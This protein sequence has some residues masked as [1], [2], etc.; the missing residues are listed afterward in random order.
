[1]MT[2][3]T[4]QRAPSFYIGDVEIKG[5]VILAP[6]AGIT[7]FSYRK[8][9]KPFGAS[10]VYTEMI[11]DCG[12]LYGNSGTKELL[13]GD[14][15]ER[16]IS[17]QLFGGS[18]ETLTKAVELLQKSKIHYDILDLNLACPVYKVIKNNGGSSRLKDQSKLFEMV[19]TVVK[20][21]EKPVSCKIRLGRDD[22][23]V[24]ETVKALENAG[25]S[26]IAIHART[27]EQF[28][29]GKPNFEALKNIRDIIKIPFCVSGDIYTVKDAIDA[30]E[31]TRCDAI[32]VARGGIGNPKLLTNINLAL[33]GKGFNE[34]K[35]ATEQTSFLLNFVDKLAEEYPE[36]KAISLLR[37]IAPKFFINVKDTKDVRVALS[38]DMNSYEDLRKIVS[39]FKG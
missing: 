15:S 25:C 14:G 8:F 12:L 29:T 23:N 21:S 4:V 26:F 20:A 35:N 2:E 17:L 37:G 24:E 6:M 30:I 36:C 34:E 33:G 1:M 9:M 16:P 18:K 28:Y 32:M 31:R 7:S 38:R 39:D 10:L 3:E 22:I 5:R 13:Y 11:S 19:S 27:R